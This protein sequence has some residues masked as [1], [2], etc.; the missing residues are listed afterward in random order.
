MVRRHVAVVPVAAVDDQTN[1]ALTYA[2]TLAPQVLAVHIRTL[3]GRQAQ[4]IEDAWERSGAS[5]PLLIVD[6]SSVSSANA[7]RR[8][9]DV[10]MR[11]EQLDR[12][13]VVVPSHPPDHQAHESD[14]TTWC[15]AL[16]GQQRI[17]V[18]HTPAG[19]AAI[20]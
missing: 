18:R 16:R 15:N 20:D 6:A 7:F 14:V 3:K 12:I 1:H 2:T 10:L 17:V 9:L 5:L 13:T 11:T 4:G 8:A 19:N